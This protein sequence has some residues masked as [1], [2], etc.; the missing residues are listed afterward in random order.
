M[1][2]FSKKS[3]KNPWKTIRFHWNPYLCVLLV[4][5]KNKTKFSKTTYFYSKTLR[6]TFKNDSFPL[7]SLPACFYWF[8][9]KNKTK[10][11]KMIHFVQKCSGKPSKTIPFHWNPYLHVFINLITKKSQKSRKK[12]TKNSQFFRNVPTKFWATPCDARPFQTNPAH[13]IPQSSRINIV[14]L[15][16]CSNL[17]Q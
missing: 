15:I 12:V 6:K 9:Q 7:E 17:L 10:I 14:D 1:T 8:G 11:P 4:W 3:F 13:A 2:R 5:S 16:L